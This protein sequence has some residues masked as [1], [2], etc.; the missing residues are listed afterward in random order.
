MIQTR[1]YKIHEL[2]PY[3]NWIYFF[4][5]WGFGPRF[6]AIAAIHD[7]AGCRSAWV[8]KF[9]EKDREQAREAE[10]LYCDASAM[11]RQLDDGY[12]VGTRFGLFPAWS[13]G[14]DICFQLDGGA[15]AHLSLLRQ[16]HTEKGGTPNLCL[17]DFIRPTRPVSTDIHALDVANVAGVFATA[18]DGVMERLYATDDY[19]RML[20]QTLCDRLA[21]AAAEKLHEDVR[22][23]DWGYAPDERLT[24][25]EL[26]AEKYQGRR[27]AVGYPSMP[28]Q[29]LIF[30]MD[31]IIDFSAIGVTLTENGMM[32][33]HAAVAG[34]M[35][36]HKACRHFAVG[37]IDE[38]QLRDY[39]VRRCKD[40]A[41]VRRFLTAN[42]QLT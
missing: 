35:L 16:Q 32:C 28:D 22:R 18:V 4:H 39:A 27:P 10:K 29:S 26:F 38:A 5:A 13:E 41:F 25:A 8:G 19:C 6:S 3:I 9:A 23:H 12:T 7:C 42:M 30:D 21:E 14:D 15:T 36:G 20:V 40:I 34:L 37:H 31:R 2:T 33:P 11:L 17:A 1:H 24:A